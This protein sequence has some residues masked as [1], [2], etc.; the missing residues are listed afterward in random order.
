VLE[1]RVWA[2]MNE[3]VSLL[4]SLLPFLILIGVWVV[5]ARGRLKGSMD[6]AR[7]GL[8]LQKKINACLE[9]IKTELKRR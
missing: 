6:I 9:E 2:K 8:E 3:W 7:E 1:R 4:A 5:F